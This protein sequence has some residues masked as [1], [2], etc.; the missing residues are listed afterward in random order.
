MPSVLCELLHEPVV[1][2]S[3]DKSMKKEFF[4]CF[5]VTIVRF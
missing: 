2:D 1:D 4:Y 3:G 5:P